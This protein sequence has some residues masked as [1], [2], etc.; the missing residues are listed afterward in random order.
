MGGVEEDYSA[1]VAHLFHGIVDQNVAGIHL[2]QDGVT[3]YV[4][5]RFAEFF[6]TSPRRLTNRPL[7]D[8]APHCSGRA[9]SIITATA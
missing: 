1:N 3:Q 2:V 7:E 4:N 9:W 6:G 8:I 5:D